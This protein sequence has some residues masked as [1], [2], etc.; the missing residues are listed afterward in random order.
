MLIVFAG[1]IARFPIGGH[2]WA[3]L[4]Y[5]CGLRDL[6]HDVYYLEDFGEGCW[7]YL[8]DADETSDDAELAAAYLEDCLKPFGFGARWMLRVGERS[9]GLPSDAFCDLCRTADLLLIR[10]LPFRQ[11]RPEYD[12]PRRRAFIDVDPGFTQASLARGEPAL[13]STL[14]RCERLFTV[15]QRIGSTDCPVPVLGREW[16]PMVPPV[17]LPGWPCAETADAR[18]PF[19]TVLQWRSYGTA[20][21][22]EDLQHDGLPYGQK[23]EA[24]DAYFDL[25][26]HTAQPMCVA[27][28]GGPS[29]RFRQHGWQVLTGWRETR[30]PALYRRFIQ[31]SRAEFAPAKRGYVVSR[32]G[33]FSDRSVCYLASG[34]PVL[35]ED[36]GLADWLPVGSGVLTFSTPEQALA[37]IAAIDADYARHAR[38]ARELAETRFATDRVLPGLLGEL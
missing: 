1:S 7:F 13:N 25:P 20:H 36:T 9:L 37:G 28:S 31:R 10:A 19:T 38:A 12:W 35:V 32:A 27:L 14:A 17:W 11:W 5:L 16:L 22:Y 26:A 21:A 34:R 3:N 15:G 33:W 29:G 18:A 30:T 2:A 8:W 23:D 6:G 24:F 4:Q